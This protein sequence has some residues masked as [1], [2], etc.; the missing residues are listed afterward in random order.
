MTNKNFFRISLAAV[1]I[2][3]IA[4]V[5]LV[6]TGGKISSAQ[7]SILQAYPPPSN[8]S[9]NSTPTVVSNTG[10]LPQA[11]PAPGNVQPTS[12]PS[13]SSSRTIY[14]NGLEKQFVG[15]QHTTLGVATTLIRSQSIAV[16][17]MT[18]SK[19]TNPQWISE[20]P[21]AYPQGLSAFQA[22]K[23]LAQSYSPQTP[24]NVPA[25]IINILSNTPKLSL[26]APINYPVSYEAVQ[27]PA[28]PPDSHIAI[29]PTDIVAV[30]N[31][32][33]SFF[34]KSN[35]GNLINQYTFADW[36]NGLV[37]ADTL[38]Y[39]SRV[40][41][42][43][44]N[45]RSIMVAAGK[46]TR[47]QQSQ[48]LISVSQQSSV[49]GTW[50]KYSFDASTN[51]GAPT[52]NW[53]DRPD[54]GIDGDNLFITA[55]MYDF[56]TTNF[57]YAKIKAFLLSE[58]YSGNI[59]HI[60]DAWNLINTDGT[61]ASIVQPASRYE[62]KG[63]MFFV[64]SGS[65]GNLTLWLFTNPINAPSL[66]KNNISVLPFSN[67]PNAQQP[68][69]Q[70]LL[71]T[72]DARVLQAQYRANGIWAVHHISYDFGT[73]PRSVV[74]LY[75]IKADGSGLW[76]QITFGNPDYFLFYP[77]LTTDI[78]GNLLVSFCITSRTDMNPPLYA[79]IAYT[80]RL[81][82]DPPDVIRSYYVIVKEGEGSY[83]NGNPSRW[84]DYSGTALDPSDGTTE[85]IFN[86]Y[87]KSGNNIST[88]IATTTF[89]INKDYIP[90]I[91]NQ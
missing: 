60:T 49:I 87:A 43:Q 53:A 33:I 29:G 27:Q 90:F 70:T 18:I 47:T 10:Q 89:Y 79:S 14:D 48:F 75:E 20:V 31:Y 16:D 67:P 82:S 66:T 41:F 23:Q 25:Q 19:Q 1:A 15:I 84:G 88:W 77:S 80:G 83:S 6:I 24:A 61:K 45:S 13:V 9:I 5:L 78:G 26:Q 32:K 81:F 11:Y 59:T 64:N 46:N 40:I 44:W 91:S 57:Q 2:F 54:V 34:D 76:N 52:S 36:Y 30:V 42:D 85:W 37:L 74:R 22:L 65:S 58:V 69:T 12:S 71:S 3:F 68:G 56:P 50:I 63:G 8:S 73:G 28:S 55:N 35:P 7:N 86:Q 4:V 38:V 51:N 62:S 21:L 17:K 39:D 72:V